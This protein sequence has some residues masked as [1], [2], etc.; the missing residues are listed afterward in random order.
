MIPITDALGGEEN[1]TLLPWLLGRYVA[2]DAA[3]AHREWVEKLE[4]EKND[5]EYYYYDDEGSG[6]VE[7]DGSGYDEIVGS[8]DDQCR[9]CTEEEMEEEEAAPRFFFNF[10]T[11]RR[12]ACCAG[13][14]VATR[15]TTEATGPR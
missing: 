3:T 15:T 1:V 9:L 14:A 8:G 4:Q 11:T 6:E 5:R 13:E 7:Y 12:V 10:I 2:K